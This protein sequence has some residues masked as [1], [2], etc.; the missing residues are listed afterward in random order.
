MRRDRSS[1]FIVRCYGAKAIGLFL[2]GRR[3]K[4]PVSLEQGEECVAL[5]LE[6]SPKED[7]PPKARIVT[8]GWNR[9]SFV[10]SATIVRISVVTKVVPKCRGSASAVAFAPATC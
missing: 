2:R 9:M 6:N 10:Q 3:F 4:E 8:K 1:T 7:P 5:A